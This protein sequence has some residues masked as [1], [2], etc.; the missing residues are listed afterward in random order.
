ML[1]RQLR[2]STQN[3]MDAKVVVLRAGDVFDPQ[4]DV[5]ARGRVFL[6]IA[7]HVKRT[8]HPPLPPRFSLQLLYAREKF[9]ADAM[10]RAVQSAACERRSKQRVQQH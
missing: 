3:E 1:E 6:L 9:E 7:M 5:C 2:L 8:I 10:A 4:R